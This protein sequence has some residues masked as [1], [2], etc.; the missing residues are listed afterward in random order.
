[1]WPDVENSISETFTRLFLIVLTTVHYVTQ[2]SKHTIKHTIYFFF[3]LAVSGAQI[4]KQ[5]LQS[6]KLKND[7]S[8]PV[9]QRYFWHKNLCPLFLKWIICKSMYFDNMFN[10]LYVASNQWKCFALLAVHGALFGYT[11]GKFLHSVSRLFAKSPWESLID[12]S[13]CCMSA[14]ACSHLWHN[15]VTLGIDPFL[16]C[17][18]QLSPS[19]S[20]DEDECFRALEKLKN[21][22][23][24]Q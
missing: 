10:G 18:R 3:L 19:A 14:S 21:L 7:V 13:G 22:W 12:C 9:Q 23:H 15:L 11:N 5:A 17:Q 20:R 24:R 1:M 4:E 8:F 2:K 16:P 6:P